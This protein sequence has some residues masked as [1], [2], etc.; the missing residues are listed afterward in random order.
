MRLPTI[1]GVIRRRLLVNFRVDPDVIQRQLP[2]RFRP[3]LLGDSA[4][5]GICLIRL[6]E[7]RPRHLPAGIGVSSES[8]A[9]RVA[10]QWT[11]EA[12]VEREGVYIPRR[13]TSSRVNRALGGRLFPGQHEPADFEISDTE[14]GID[15]SMRS[16]DGSAVVRLRGRASTALPESSRFRSLAEASSF[17]EAGSIGYSAG[18]DDRLD[19][20]RLE[21]TSW[22][23]EPLAVD[24]VFSSYFADERHFPPGSV[25]FDCALIMRDVPHTWH[26]LSPVSRLAMS[27]EP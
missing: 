21:T 22:R 12:G 4:I 11:D 17:F 7:M 1:Q 26:A 3:K 27:R 18:S 14:S 13:D 24:E 16:R 2:S 23:V 15:F 8:G 10:V 5:A 25:A 19:G 20:L 6:E 9:H